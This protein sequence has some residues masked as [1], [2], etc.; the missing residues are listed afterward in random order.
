[1]IALVGRVSK[2]DD[3]SPYYSFVDQDILTLA[4][5]WTSCQCLC[6]HLS[7]LWTFNPPHF[8]S[9]PFVGFLSCFLIMQ[10]SISVF[11]D[12]LLWL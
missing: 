5:C 12:G 1:M 4:T 6:S 11:D 2:K 9:V 3:G 7:Q 10:I 8:L